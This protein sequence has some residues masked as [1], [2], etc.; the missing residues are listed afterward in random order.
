M[1]L[2]TI[3]QWLAVAVL[4]VTLLVFSAIG[5]SAKSLTPSNQYGPLTVTVIS[6]CSSAQTIVNISIAPPITS[7]TLTGQANGSLHLYDTNGKINTN[8]SGSAPYTF[9]TRQSDAFYA[10]LLNGSSGTVSFAGQIDMTTANWAGYTV[11]SLSASPNEYTDLVGHWKVPAV[12]CSLFPQETSEIGHVD[13]I[14]GAPNTSSSKIEQIGTEQ[15]C[16]GGIP[17]Y[18]PVYENFP[19]PKIR[20]FTACKLSN[21]PNPCITVHAL[22]S[23]NDSMQASIHYY[24][25]NSTFSFILEDITQNWYATESY[26]SNDPS[27]RYSAEWIEEAPSSSLSNFH[28]VNFTFSYVD[29]HTISLGGPSVQQLTIKGGSTIKAQPTGLSQTCCEGD[30][31]SVIFKN[32]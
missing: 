1:V 4:V 28:Q 16:I 2:P 17:T 14:G 27:I 10:C 32:H 6:K 25:N 11:Q 19:A 5:A 23:A 29:G 13:R 26:Q 3:R 12:S 7:I 31:F 20:I 21:Y 18:Y 22:M 9:T 30:I 24:S 15:N 8:V